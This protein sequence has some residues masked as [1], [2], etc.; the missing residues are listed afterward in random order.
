MLF[1]VAVYWNEL[2]QYKYEYKKEIE[3]MSQYVEQH[4]RI[5][6]MGTG[7][8]SG[9]ITEFLH[10]R[11]LKFD[12]YVI[13]NNQSTNGVFYGKKVLHLQDVKGNKDDI[14]VI[15]AIKKRYQEEYDAFSL[16]DVSRILMMLRH[17]GEIHQIMVGEVLHIMSMVHRAIMH[18]SL[19]KLSSQGQSCPLTHGWSF[20]RM[21]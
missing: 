8:V 18:L 12:G 9:I 10:K 16:I 2:I 13:S 11:G 7:D 20:G 19:A 15:I 5:Y 1:D 21:S 3:R 14:G 17:N 6:V 4:N